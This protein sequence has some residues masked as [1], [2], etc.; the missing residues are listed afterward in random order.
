LEK[1]IRVK[2]AVV[3]GNTPV[4]NCLQNYT[5]YF[6]DKWNDVN[7]RITIRELIRNMVDKIVV[8]KDTKS[9]LVYFKGGEEAVEVK[10][11]KEKYTIN[12]LEFEY[13]K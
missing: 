2:E 11:G 3:R 1:D 9:Y 8:D 13:V 7:A 5:E 12:G 6:S 4:L 10:L